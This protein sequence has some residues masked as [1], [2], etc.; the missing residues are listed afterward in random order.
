[1][2]YLIGVDDAGRGPVIGP[3]VLAGVLIE[4][5]KED[6]LKKVGVKDSKQI[7]PSTR[8]KIRE[9]LENKVEYFLQI[10]SPE[11]ID[12]CNNLNTLEAERMAVIINKLSLEKKEKIKVFVDCPSNNKK[13]WGDLLK[14]LLI[15]K[16]LELFIE[17]KADII[18]PVVSAAS[19][20]A[21][22]KREEEIERIKRELETDFGSGYPSDPK[23]IEFIKKNFNNEKFKKIIRFS[24]ES[25]KRLNIA[26]EQKKLF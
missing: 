24:W 2:T 10:I 15:R 20:I 7:F 22:E 11:E 5:K 1:M 3:M 16:D 19:I 12:S 14:S 4:E 13:K 6:F 26:E 18:Y 21:K 17:H 25:I 9:I 8:K 23:T